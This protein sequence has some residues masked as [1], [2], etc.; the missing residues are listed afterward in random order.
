[1][2]LVTIPSLDNGLL[3][4]F[5]SICINHVL[6]INRKRP[7][8]NDRYS[9]EEL[10]AADKCNYIFIEL[11][12]RWKTPGCLRIRR[13]QYCNFLCYYVLSSHDS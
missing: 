5:I 12:Q 7:V 3:P 2:D 11:T 6:V 8:I 4:V 1:M 13:L 9:A 10:N